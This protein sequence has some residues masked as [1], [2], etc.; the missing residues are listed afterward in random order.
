MPSINNVSNQLTT[1][2]VPVQGT[3][4]QNGNIINLIGPAGKPFT[5]L[6]NSAVLSLDANGNPIGI[7]NPKNNLTIK[8]NK[9][10][11]M[12]E[13]YGRGA[14]VFS[15]VGWTGITS[16]P[17]TTFQNFIA[18]RGK[19]Y[20][21]RVVYFN[22]LT[23]PYTINNTYAFKSS[24]EP[25][26]VGNTSISPTGTAQA[27]LF[28]GSASAVVPACT[29]AGVPT[30]LASDWLTLNPIERTDYPNT[31]Y[32][33]AFRSYTSLGG[34]AID[35]D[36]NGV[37]YPLNLG[38]YSSTNIPNLTRWNEAISDA[39]G[40]IAASN[41]GII[42]GNDNNVIIPVYFEFAVA[43]K[44]LKVVSVGDS[45]TA[46]SA[47]GSPTYTQ[48]TS[49]GGGIWGFVERAVNLVN[50]QIASSNYYLSHINTGVGGQVV[51]STSAQSFYARLPGLLASATPDVVV[52]PAWS[53]NSAPST[54]AAYDT[55][56]ASVFIG[57]QQITT[58]GAIPL[59]W[60]SPPA[61]AFLS[62]A[63]EV[64][65]L[66]SNTLLRQL[67]TSGNIALADIDAVMSN[68]VSPKADMIS[69]YSNDTV[70]PNLTGNGVMA[71]ALANILAGIAI[72]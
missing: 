51:L 17:T 57:I 45:I 63:Q 33:Y 34:V 42:R 43:A 41:T 30:Y 50:N 72:E 53:P 70:H 55:Q 28:S 36:S 65:R 56:L 19:P 3:F 2:I 5:S 29:V 27:V 59:L 18:T 71:T 67:A 10:R 37:T 32:E 13:Q 9:Q 16:N 64:Y 1:N 66:K 26:P 38:Q 52:I 12:V 21:V 4:D 68:N 48:A 40:S 15:S 69:G 35:A 8:N 60:T 62:D 58:A 44:V 46:G 14:G 22:P 49:A 23:T 54:Q 20:A 11:G 6:P 39:T 7:V 61:S 25:A 47:V 31:F 24:T